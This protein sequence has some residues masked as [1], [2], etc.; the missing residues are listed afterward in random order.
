M[1]KRPRGFVS[2]YRPRARNA[3]LLEQV[4]QVLDE[5]AD[6][7]PLSLRQ[8]F[9][10]LV[11]AYAYTKT[12]AAYKALCEMLNMARRAR[13]IPFDAIRDDGAMVIAPTLW[14]SELQWLQ[15]VTRQA[16]RLRL[17]PWIH[18]PAYVE[19]ICEAGGMAP[20]LAQVADPYGIT[21]R[22]GGG[23]DS[24]TAKYELAQFYAQQNKPVIVL[25]VGDYDASGETLWNVLDEDVGAFVSEIGGELQVQR[26]AVTPEQVQEYD[27][28]TAPPKVKDNRGSY[29]TDTVTA[30]AEAFP[31]ALLQSIV[32]DAIEATMDLDQLAV[33]R[34]V[35]RL[36]RERLTKRLEGLK[37]D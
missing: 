16:G 14:D 18:Q 33:T 20:M 28:P 17:N 19:L 32:R 4:Q 7:L 15:A 35:E 3:E 37:D 11:G 8:V 36:A 5:Y 26:V 1:G 6:F 21:V 29:F 34:E 2:D 12:E 10:R 30:Q 22:S 23:F 24:T 13:L 31:P 27:L 25:H 9:Y